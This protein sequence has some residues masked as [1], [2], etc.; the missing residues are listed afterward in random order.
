MSS[1]IPHTANNK[2]D[3]VSFSEL[4]VAGCMSNAA[5]AQAARYSPKAKA[6]MRRPMQKK[7]TATF[8]ASAPRMACSGRM[9]FRESVS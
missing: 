6:P 3:I 8:W 5:K 4:V 2:E 1:C 7:R 9:I